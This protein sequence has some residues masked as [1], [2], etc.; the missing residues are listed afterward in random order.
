[1]YVDTSKLIA[2]KLR[3]MSVTNEGREQE[4]ERENKKQDPVGLRVL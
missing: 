2:I 3:T 4:R 1:M